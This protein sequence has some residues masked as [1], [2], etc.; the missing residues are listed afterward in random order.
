MRNTNEVKRLIK[1]VTYLCM[2]AILICLQASIAL[3]QEPAK[4]IQPANDAGAAGSAPSTSPKSS[5]H[6]A[7]VA[8]AKPLT[9][10]IPIY[11]RL[12]VKYRIMGVVR[13]AV[14]INSKGII[15]SA[16]ALD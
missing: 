13:I 5:N 15:T 1:G 14:E 11:P 9:L 4:V 3:A 12:A 10:P 7:N 2:A 16:H 8:T 6:T